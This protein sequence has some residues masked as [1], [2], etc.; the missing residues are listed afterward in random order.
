MT[1]D[2]NFMRSTDPSLLDYLNE[3]ARL[4]DRYRNSP[5]PSEELIEQFALYATPV[6]LR[7]FIHLDKSI[8]RG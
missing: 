3:L 8:T 5:I 6:S 4:R 2:Q 7:R 1:K